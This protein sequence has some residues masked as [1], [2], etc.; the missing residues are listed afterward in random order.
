MKK[1]TLR[2]VKKFSSHFIYYYFRLWIKTPSV[3][4]WFI[5][6]FERYLNNKLIRVFIQS[7]KFKMKTKWQKCKFSSQLGTKRTK[8]LILF[9]GIPLSILCIPLSEIVECKSTDLLSEGPRKNL[10]FRL[11]TN[12]MCSSLFIKWSCC[13][14]RTVGSK[15]FRDYVCMSRQLVAKY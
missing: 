2:N 3:L 10:N 8:G 4:L 1:K 12:L 11:V 13:D 14:S 15:I 9:L 6:K 5:K 7:K